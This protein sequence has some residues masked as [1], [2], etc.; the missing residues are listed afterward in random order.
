MT[1]AMVG[2]PSLAN[3]LETLE[4]WFEGSEETFVVFPTY[5]TIHDDGD[6][7]VPVHAWVFE[8]EEDSTARDAV[9]GMLKRTLDIDDEEQR[10]RF[11]RRIRPF[12]VDNERG[13]TVELVVDEHAFTIGESAPDGHIRKRIRIPADVAANVLQVDG[14]E[15][16]LEAKCTTSFGAEKTRRIPLI[17]ESGVTVVS[18]ID[19]TIKVTNVLDRSEMMKNTFLEEFHAVEGMSS[20]YRRLREDHDAAFHYVSASPWQLLAF[21]QPFLS[22]AGFPEGT[23]HL[24][25]LRPKSIRSPME[26]AG[27][28]SDYKSQTIARLMNDF[29]KRRFLLVGDSSEHDPEV[30]GKIAREHAESVERI[31]I[32]E[33]DGGDNSEE[34]FAKAFREVPTSVWQTF[35]APAEIGLELRKSKP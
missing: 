29:P 7:T 27:S 35:E 10:K 21:L 13:K 14:E 15:R 22:E 5:A 24:R 32:R 18:D 4:S 19:D 12:L 9:V 34:R 1:V 30:Y 28:S 20:L 25:K 16:W 26:F 31:L 23:Y 3:A 33:V 6:L 17:E 11:D 8:P 2:L